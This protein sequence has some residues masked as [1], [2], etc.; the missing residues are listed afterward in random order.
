VNSA[1]IFRIDQNLAELAAQALRRVKYQ[2]REDGN[3]DHIC[4]LLSG[5]ATVA[6]VTR[7][8]D[9]ASEVRILTRVVRRRGQAKIAADD[10]MRIGLIAAASNSALGDWCKF[11]GDWLTEHAFEDLE[12]ETGAKLHSHILRLCHIEHK[13]WQTCARADAACAALAGSS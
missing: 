7:S 4:S 6:A 5:L 10:A 11:L 1:L 3:E 8:P 9:L 2:L 13:L 12:K